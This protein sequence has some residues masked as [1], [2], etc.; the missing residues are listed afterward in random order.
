ML[1][2]TKQA[3][4]NL[5]IAGFR[6]SEFSVRAERNY[7]GRHPNTGKQ[8]FEYGKPRITVFAPMKKVMDLT[9][10][11][12][13]QGISVTYSLWQDDEG[14]RKIGFPK[15]EDDGKGQL[16]LWNTLKNDK[17]PLGEIEDIEDINAI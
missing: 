17:N 12:L 15:L 11:I 2:Q 6:R 10:A 5:K 16:L 9:E 1:I 13:T 3:I 4:D 7:V 14:H 8:M